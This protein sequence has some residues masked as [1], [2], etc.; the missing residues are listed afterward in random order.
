MS[1]IDTTSVVSVGK[2]GWYMHGHPG[3]TIF[4]PNDGRWYFNGDMVKPTFS[5][6]VNEVSSSGNYGHHFFVRDGVVEYVEK[7]PKQTCCDGAERFYTMPPWNEK[8]LT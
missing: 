5:P 1:D 6:S 4:V 2:D 8:Q 7:R 3:H